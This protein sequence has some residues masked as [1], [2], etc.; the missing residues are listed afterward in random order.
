MLKYLFSLLL[1]ITIILTGCNRGI[2][3]K[4]PGKW[5]IDGEPDVLTIEF[6]KDGRV[7]NTYGGAG[8]TLEG[9]WKVL[10]ENTVAISMEPWDITGELVEKKLIL[11]SGENEKIYCKI[12]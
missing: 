6:F 10:T 4:L 11:K 9:T 1:S 8:A 5:V 2:S 12:E 7:V 3:S